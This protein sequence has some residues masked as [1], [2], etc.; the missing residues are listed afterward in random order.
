M[1]GKY[2]E[3]RIASN[4]AIGSTRS[5]V[6]SIRGKMD[7]RKQVLFGAIQASRCWVSTQCK[8]CTMVK[9]RVLVS[10]RCSYQG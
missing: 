3:E 8:K 6:I 4:T 10:L 1:F 5:V 2:P 9:G 7:G